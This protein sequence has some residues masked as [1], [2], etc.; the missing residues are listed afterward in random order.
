MAQGLSMVQV[1]ADSVGK[2]E[3]GSKLRKDVWMREIESC[4]ALFFHIASV[5]DF[6]RGML[7]GAWPWAIPRYPG[8]R[9]KAFRA[10]L[11][12]YVEALE[13]ARAPA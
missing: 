3:L 10:L 12:L 6:K 5:I 13:R 9:T 1:L 7:I 4:V 11:S 8:S 2:L